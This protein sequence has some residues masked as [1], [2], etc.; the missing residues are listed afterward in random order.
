M[1]RIGD[2]GS[3]AV[4]YLDLGYVAKETGQLED[5]IEHCKQAVTLARRMG[6]ETTMADAFRMTA[7]AYLKG[8]RYDDAIDACQTSLAIAQRLKDELRMASAWYLMAEGYE[9]QGKIQKAVDF[10]CQ[11]PVRLA[12]L[13]GR[14]R[15]TQ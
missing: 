4:A 5:A 6:Q 14:S 9:R 1:D 10:A 2:A 13:R 11:T 3:K 7:R 15:R 12:R 8:R